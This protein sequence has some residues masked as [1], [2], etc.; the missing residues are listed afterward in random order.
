MTSTRDNVL[1]WFGAAISLAEMISGTLFAPLGLAQGALA[2]VLGHLIGGLLM[3]GCGLIGAR[4]RQ[5]A[6][7]T[8]KYTFGRIGGGWFASLN[9]LQLLGWTAVMVITGAQ[10]CQLFL[11]VSLGF[12]AA[13]IGAVTVLWLVI[14]LQDLGPLN[15]VAMLAL[16]AACVYLSVRILGAGSGTVHETGSLSFGAA[17]ELAIAMPLSWLPLIS[18]YTSKAKKPVHATVWSVIV[19]N[20]TSGW[21]YLIGLFGVVLTGQ[22]QIAALMQH[23][24]M[25]IIALVVVILATITT[26]FLDVFSAGV[27]G[28]TLFNRLPVK[29]QAIGITVAGTV[30][31]IFVPMSAYENF[32]YWISSVF[33]PM[34]VIQ[35]VD[36]F[37]GHHRSTMAMDWPRMVLW[38]CGVALY[39][40]FLTIQTPLGSTIPVVI[41]LAI[42]SAILTRVL[43][44]KGNT[45]HEFTK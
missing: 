15:R 5:P 3:L 2:I 19:Y 45:S 41:I 35:I 31:G 33:V 39:R 44:S 37:F 32:L 17:L 13:V 38:I 28:N 18:D 12:W 30:V 25:G 23:F 20:L 29:W 16:L 42:L 10:A 14:G 7:V 8:T 22:T 1:L 40:Y 27:S 36:Y 26:T 34:A 21:M 9:V 6:M 43:P 4:T 11:P 24:G